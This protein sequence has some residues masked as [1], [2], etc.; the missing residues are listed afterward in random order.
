MNRITDSN[1]G[2][3]ERAK[4]QRS[5]QERTEP[6]TGFHGAAECW[7]LKAPPPRYRS[8]FC[9]GLVWAT[10]HP[11]TCSIERSGSINCC[12][13]R[14]TR[15]FGSANS[16]RSVRLPQ[17]RQR[18]RRWWYTTVTGCAAQG[19]SCRVRSFISRTR[20]VRRPHPLQGHQRMPR[21]STLHPQRTVRQVAVTPPTR[22]PRSR[23][24]ES[25]GTLSSRSHA[26]SLVAGTSREE[27]LVARW[28]L[29][30]VTPP[31]ASHV[32]TPAGGNGEGRSFNP[33]EFA[34]ALDQ[35]VA[36][37]APD[38]YKPGSSPVN[39][40][41]HRPVSRSE[42][43]VI[44]PVVVIRPE[45][46]DCALRAAAAA[47]AVF[48]T[49]LSTMLLPRN[50]IGK[51][52]S[53]YFTRNSGCSVPPCGV[54]TSRLWSWQCEHMQRCGASTAAIDGHGEILAPIYGVRDGKSRRHR[55]QSCFKQNR[56]RRRV[57]Q[58]EVP[59]IGAGH[60]PAAR[61]EHRE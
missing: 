40:S 23:L 38:D 59:P 41:R 45:A 36:G 55:W 8:A 54:M 17:W 32:S 10:T 5:T 35:V 42:R 29:G 1:L 12:S 27:H 3:A 22:P 51:R 33:N 47:T 21:R 43:V 60:K 48:G 30:R 52:C 50:V 53:R 44:P 34:I 49:H 31:I 13:R 26:S 39:R 2:R 56:A 16:M 6:L 14:V 24:S 37:T 61:R 9:R 57:V 46:R 28:Q 4:R 19:R 7:L 20:P 25:P 11:R 58:I 18:T 15:A